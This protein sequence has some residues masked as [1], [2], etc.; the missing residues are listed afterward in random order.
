MA[1]KIKTPDECIIGE[2]EALRSIVRVGTALGISP[3]Y[4]AKRLK[5]NGIERTG[6]EGEPPKLKTCAHCGRHFTKPYGHRTMEKIRFCSQS[7][8]GAAERATALERIY[9]YSIPEP[10]SGCWLWLR[11]V[12]PTGYGR[13]GFDRP[14]TSAHRA[15]YELHFGA[16]PD[17]AHVLHKCDTPCCI[18]PHHLYLGDPQQN[19]ADKIAR[20]RQ[21]RGERS[22]QAKLSADDVKKIRASKKRT[23]VLAREFGI[24]AS[25]ISSI[26]HQHIWLEP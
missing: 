3:A 2:Y 14:V 9:E 20:G 12:K 11:S 19:T 8:A 22:A 7:C 24:S 13:F 4:V 18:N 16:I 23:S 1:K 5:A 21:P 17:G 10:N 6:R 25:V 15:S 26:R